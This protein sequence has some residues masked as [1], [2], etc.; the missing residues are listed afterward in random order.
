[1][2]IE[3]RKIIFSS[4]N[5]RQ[6]GESGII[7]IDQ[8]LQV[9]GSG[10]DVG[11]YRHGY[12]EFGEENPLT[13][14][15]L[16]ELADHMIERWRAFRAHVATAD[17][18][19]ISVDAEKLSDGLTRLLAYQLNKDEL[20]VSAN[21]RLCGVGGAAYIDDI[22]TAKTFLDI[23]AGV[24]ETRYGCAVA[25]RLNNCQATQSVKLL[26]KIKTDSAI[27]RARI[28]QQC[29]APNKIPVVEK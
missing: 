7:G 8:D 29:F 22:N 20:C 6:I 15:D 11:I 28:E 14:E 26:K 12:D 18:Y 23:C 17:Y 13:K 24:L 2:K 4:G 10:Y 9:V 19:T 16:I 27:V 21:L 1:M 5:E 25:L 3:G